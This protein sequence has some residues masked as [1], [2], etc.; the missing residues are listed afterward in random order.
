LRWGLKYFFTSSEQAACCSSS[1][2]R[3]FQR[4]TGTVVKIRARAGVVQRPVAVASIDGI[5]RFDDG[6]ERDLQR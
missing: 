6:G 5:G 1:F 3:T 4:K 2:N